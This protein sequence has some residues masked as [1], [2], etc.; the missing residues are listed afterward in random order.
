MRTSRVLI[1]LTLLA[2]LTVDLAVAAARHGNSLPPVGRPT[3]DRIALV[4]LLSSQVAL[5]ALW[6]VLGRT[7]LFWRGLGTV[8]ATFLAGW[9]VG[10]LLNAVH[11]LMPIWTVLLC[12]DSAAVLVVLGAARHRGWRLVFPGEPRPATQAGA[13]PLQ[14]SLSALLGL[15]TLLAIVLS[16]LRWALQ[17]R[18]VMLSTL[19]F[20]GQALL[21][22]GATAGVTV[23]AVWTLLSDARGWLR[24][25]AFLGVLAI[26]GAAFWLSG[27]F[28]GPGAGLFS[29]LLGLCL[30]ATLG[31]FRVTGFRV[32]LVA[33]D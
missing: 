1:L 4:A 6:G 5:V 17:D 10:H 32:G 18:P 8:L 2:W 24:L 15:M 33:S 22:S 20:W 7:R 27:E 26:A 16:L 3:L 11:H 13:A 23:C 30:A 21:V 28:G 25:A 12:L 19:V 29:L 14:F 31:V 9:L